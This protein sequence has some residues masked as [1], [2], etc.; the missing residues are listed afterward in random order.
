MLLAIAMNSANPRLRAGRVLAIKPKLCTVTLTLKVTAMSARA[1]KT[2]NHSVAMYDFALYRFKEL[3][4]WDTYFR[5]LREPK[6]K[7]AVP[8]DNPQIHDEIITQ[9]KKSSFNLKNYEID[10]NDYRQYMKNAEYQKFPSYQNNCKTKNFIEKTLEHYLAAK[11]LN[12]SKDD[13]YIDIASAD[14]PTPEIYSKLYGCKVYRQDIMFP[15]GVHGNII[16]GDAS[17][18]PIEDGFATKMG[19]HCSFE[20]FENNSDIKFIKETSRILRKGGKLCILPLYLFNKYA[21]QTNPAV[22]PKGG[23]PFENDATLYCV[24]DWASRHNRFYNVPHLTARIRNN[25]NQ[26]EM[27]IYIIQNQKK[28]ASSCYIKFA[29]LIEKNR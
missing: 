26:L 2:V 9:L 13:V 22:M 3:L 4:L 17:Q 24:K 10:V 12:P 11:L 5:A 1:E 29:A 25:L 6:V 23:I 21:I 18:M 20:H 16:G 7:Q 14:S 8:H 15:E 28:V 19:L 27:T